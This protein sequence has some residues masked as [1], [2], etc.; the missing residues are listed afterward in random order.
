MAHYAPVI[1]EEEDEI[2]ILWKGTTSM[3]KTGNIP[4]NY[5]GKDEEEADRS[6]AGCSSWEDGDCYYR[7][8]R[9]IAAHKQMQRAYAKDPE[10]GKER[11]SLDNAL[12]NSVR[13]ARYVRMAVGGDPWVIKRL[14]MMR[15]RQ[16]IHDYGF[17]GMLG[18]TSMWREKGAH[19]M[20]LV[21][22]SCKSLAEADEAIAAGWRATVIIHDRKAPGC[23]KSKLNAIP[24]WDGKER[25]FTP[26]GV[27]V[28]PCPSQRQDI[29]KDCNTCGL[30]DATKHPAVK[31]VGFFIH[32]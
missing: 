18:Y 22:A 25:I 29:R 17:E 21:M 20:G 27:E 4:I 10:K 5:I 30:C 32:A 13:I 8:G 2:T 14:R 7:N 31:L 11:Y 3:E 6:C 16:K 26:E 9:P 23:N 28:T 12:G 15:I 19:L 1:D 24:E